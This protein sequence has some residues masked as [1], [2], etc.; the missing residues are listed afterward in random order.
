M[1]SVGYLPL[2]CELCTCHASSFSTRRYTRA[3]LP[4]ISDMPRPALEAAPSPGTRVDRRLLHRSAIT[5]PLDITK[6]IITSP[7]STNI[8]HPS[9]SRRISH[10]NYASITISR[11]QLIQSHSASTS[12]ETHIYP[13]DKTKHKTQ[14]ASHNHG[15][16]NNR[17]PPQP[18]RTPLTNPHNPPTPPPKTK[19]ALLSKHRPPNNPLRPPPSRT[20]LQDRPLRL[21]PRPPSRHSPPDPL[22]SRPA[23]P[24]S[25]LARSLAEDED[26]D[27]HARGSSRRPG[28]VRAR[29]AA[30][31]GVRG[32]GVCGPG[33]ERVGPVCGSAFLRAGLLSCCWACVLGCGVVCL[34]EADCGLLWG[35]EACCSCEVAHSVCEF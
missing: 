20:N 33:V 27:A 24:H 6:T 16:P 17:Q 30:R 35:G 1:T 23:R 11:R 31:A 32:R 15:T 9:L 21:R 29:R 28:H 3:L 13:N 8:S 12:K 2:A 26:E 5:K 7:G 25:S 34:Y 10:N 14:T 19:L 22:P 18:P 4:H